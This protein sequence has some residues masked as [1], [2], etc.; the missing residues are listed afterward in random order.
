[1]VE[2]SVKDNAQVRWYITITAG[3]V[4]KVCRLYYYGFKRALALQ[5]KEFLALKITLLSNMASLEQVCWTCLI[6]LNPARW[7]RKVRDPRFLLSMNPLAPISSGWMWHF[8]PVFFM[9]LYLS[10]FLDLAASML[11][12]ESQGTVS[13]T[14]WTVKGDVL[15]STNT[16]SGRWP[17]T[18][19]EAGIEPPLVFQ[20]LRSE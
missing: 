9:S 20:P 10:T 2:T 12:V 11:R 7:Q 18:M 3:L 1:M 17:V 15:L 13:S 5:S 8:N 14:R 19:M 4:S 6:L 16:R